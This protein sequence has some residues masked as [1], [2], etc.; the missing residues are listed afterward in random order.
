[1]GARVEAVK[2]ARWG[3]PGFSAEWRGFN[4]GGVGVDVHEDGRW[5]AWEEGTDNK[6]SGAAS[7][8]KGAMREARRAAVEIAEGLDARDGLGGVG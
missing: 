5:A 6:A 4:A 7:G 2:K 1:M 3:Y 8:M